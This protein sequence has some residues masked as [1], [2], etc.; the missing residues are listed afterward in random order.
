[1]LLI[2]LV[3]VINIMT[4]FVYIYYLKGNIGVIYNGEKKWW[5]GE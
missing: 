4:Y 2:K 5:T 1:M 3:Y